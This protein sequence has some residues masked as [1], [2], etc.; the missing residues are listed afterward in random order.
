MTTKFQIVTSTTSVLS[1]EVVHEATLA[2]RDVLHRS[3][4]CLSVS[5]TKS[6]LDFPILTQDSLWLR[7]EDIQ[8]V[9]TH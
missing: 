2:E 8:L 3:D 5:T 9:G 1:D 6:C 4:I 7:Y